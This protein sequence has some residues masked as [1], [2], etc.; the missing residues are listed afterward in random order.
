MCVFNSDCVCVCDG[1]VSRPLPPCVSPGHSY[2]PP[3]LALDMIDYSSVVTHHP[4][5]ATPDSRAHF[6]VIKITS[7]SGQLTVRGEFVWL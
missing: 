2:P 5:S 1:P 4:N 3:P 7:G 6:L